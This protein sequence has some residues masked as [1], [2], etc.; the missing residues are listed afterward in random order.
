MIKL[1]D[2]SIINSNENNFY[3][4]NFKETEYDLSKFSSKTVIGEAFFLNLGSGNV[5]M[6]SLFIV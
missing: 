1:F 3:N 5:S 2:G 6:F 4:I